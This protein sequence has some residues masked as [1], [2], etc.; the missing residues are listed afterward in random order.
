M[1]TPLPVIFPTF[2]L[3]RTLIYSAGT[4]PTQNLLHRA[5]V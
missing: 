1:V 5:N 3:R 4:P 2:A